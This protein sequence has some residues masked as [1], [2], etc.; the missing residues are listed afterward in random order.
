MTSSALMEPPIE[1]IENLQLGIDVGNVVVGLDLY[2][3]GD[4]GNQALVRFGGPDV[5]NQM[6]MNRLSILDD[7][8]RKAS[9]LP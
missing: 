3:E 2:L 1:E 8:I 9:N 4:I 6:T 7:D 5:S